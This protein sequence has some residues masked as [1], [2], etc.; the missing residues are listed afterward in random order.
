MMVM[1]VVMIMMRWRVSGM[2]ATSRDGQVTAQNR[3]GWRWK[4]PQIWWIA[5]RVF[6]LLILPAGCRTVSTRQRRNWRIPTASTRRS[7]HHDNCHF[8]FFFI[9]HFGGETFSVGVSFETPEFRFSNRVFCICIFPADRRNRKGDGPVL[10]LGSRESSKFCLFLQN[11]GWNW[12][13]FFDKKNEDA[14]LSENG[15]CFCFRVPFQRQETR[16]RTTLAHFGRKQK[17]KQKTNALH[18]REW[19]RR[20]L[21]IKIDAVVVGEPKQDFHDLSIGRE[22]E[23]VSLF[24]PFEKKTKKQKR[25]S[26]DIGKMSDLSAMLEEL[27]SQRMDSKVVEMN[28]NNVS[29]LFD[30]SL[31]RGVECISNKKTGRK[32]HPRPARMK[33]ESGANSLLHTHIS[34]YI[35]DPNMPPPAHAFHII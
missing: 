16:T 10:S 29:Q 23:F 33:R 24:P 28:P 30:G 4:H 32:A 31:P 19:K 1:V 5:T 18:P 34:L 8:F 11:W 21:N 22:R 35:K 15:F 2:A 6:F 20:G 17:Q 12:N 9:V 14:L 25:V 13:S 3:C 27:D 26:T 7:C